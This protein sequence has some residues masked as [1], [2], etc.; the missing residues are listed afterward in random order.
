MPP[1]LVFTD[2]DGTLLD[3]FDYS[4]NAALPALDKLRAHGVPLVLCSSK[5]RA[6]LELY[7]RRL[8][9]HHPFIVENGG[10]IFIPPGYF[11]QPVGGAEMRGEYQVVAFGTS[12][13]LI[14]RHLRTL[15]ERLGV[16]VR[17]FSEMSA[18]EVAALTGLPVAEAELA[19]QRDF[20]EPFVFAGAPDQGFLQAIT[21]AGLFWTQGRFFHLMGQHHKGRA[22]R[23]LKSLYEREFGTLYSVALGDA[24]NDLPMLQEVDH[25]V[26]VRHRDGSHEQR[27][28][29][30]A[31]HITASPGPLG[32]NETLLELL[33]NDAEER[34]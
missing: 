29:L 21:D 4:F 1:M 14:R 2:L 16:A 26:L 19:R 13:A 33:D 8:D 23:F 22:V 11:S 31:L 9:N 34:T 27:V 18:S 7:R 24:Y 10:G 15:S 6:E 5:T 32:W 28:E 25:A 20:A 17:G 3:E 30:P 12:H